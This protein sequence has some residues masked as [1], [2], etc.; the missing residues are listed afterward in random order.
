V[1]ASDFH[2]RQDDLRWLRERDRRP[3]P[4]SAAAR[5]KAVTE[6]L[7]CRGNAWNVDDLKTRAAVVVARKALAV[8]RSADYAIRAGY[9]VLGDDNL[10]P[11]N[12]D[13]TSDD[14]TFDPPVSRPLSAQVLTF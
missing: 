9:R 5:E 12:P 1:T 3:C 11:D 4:I 14:D 10:D 2:A 6:A 13:V 7:E 8:G